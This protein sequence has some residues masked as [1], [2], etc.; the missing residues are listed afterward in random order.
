[1]PMP[2]QIGGAPVDEFGDCSHPKQD[3]AVISH[4][5][6]YFSG[7]LIVHLIFGLATGWGPP[8]ISCHQNIGIST[9]HYGYY[10]YKP[11]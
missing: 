8:V 7:I 3:R 5:P 11:T 2:R 4:L 10:S 9:I 1:M 6:L